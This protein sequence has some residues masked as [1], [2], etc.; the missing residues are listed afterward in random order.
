MNKQTL[1]FF[2][3][4]I[5]I[6]F[7]F[8]NRFIKKRVIYNLE[9]IYV[10]NFK[11]YCI[12][13]T[14]IIILFTIVKNILF[15]LDNTTNAFPIKNNIIKEIYKYIKIVSTAP[16][17]FYDKIY[18]FK[19]FPIK[20][21]IEK[22]ISY[23]TAYL[24]YPSSSYPKLISVFFLQVPKIIVAILFFI[25]IVFF[26]QIN[27]FIKAI[28]LLSLT[29]IV[30]M[31]LFMA[32]HHS[33]KNIDYFDLHIEFFKYENNNTCYAKFREPLP[34]IPDALDT[35][36]VKLSTILGWYTIYGNIYNFTKKIYEYNS[37]ITPYGTIISSIFFLIGWGGFIY[38]F[39]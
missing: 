17:I 37:F 32:N 14:S 20:T 4:G 26:H 16:Q 30:R 5:I 7:I 24:Y 39:V 28:W 8:W 35:Q 27:Y 34:N 15:L 31:F 22:P 10:S 36:H 6:S 2:L 9:E 33:K 25:D 1:T 19:Y 29:L 23:L 13:F 3:A 38:F 11:L 18:M 12:V 21:L